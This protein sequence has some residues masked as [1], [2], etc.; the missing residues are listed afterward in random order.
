[1]S[2]FK[3]EAWMKTANVESKTK[4]SLKDVN[5]KFSN[6][7]VCKSLINNIGGILCFYTFKSDVHLLLY[8]CYFT[9]ARSL[10]VPLDRI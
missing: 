10:D 5:F 8:L 6:I 9:Q 2:I 7:F 3:R 4:K 1:M